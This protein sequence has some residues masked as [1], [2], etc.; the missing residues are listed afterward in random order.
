ML[1]NSNSNHI[2]FDSI[3]SLS[4]VTEKQHKR[5]EFY[6]MR[7]EFLEGTMIIKSCN[8][9]S[10]ISLIKE[11]LFIIRR[12]KEMSIDGITLESEQD[13]KNS[14]II[15]NK[16]FSLQHLISKKFLAKDNFYSLH[17]VLKGR[18]KPLNATWPR[19]FDQ[20]PPCSI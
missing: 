7:S 5:S 6:L 11:S 16:Q 1:E 13:K 12:P 14:E 9:F 19:Y 10:D 18:Q 3:I 8:P 15:Y 4:L 17:L 2:D 20:V